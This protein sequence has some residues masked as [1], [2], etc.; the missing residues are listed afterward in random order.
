MSIVFSFLC[1]DAKTVAGD[2]ATV[3]LSNTQIK[4]KIID[5]ASKEIKTITG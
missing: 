3:L 2:S 4:A 5:K 1:F